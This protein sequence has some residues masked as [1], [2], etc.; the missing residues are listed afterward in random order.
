MAPVSP[1]VALGSFYEGVLQSALRQFFRRAS[2]EIEPGASGADRPLTIEHTVEP[3]AL[4][5][6]WGG[7]RY[8]LRMPGRGGA[9]TPHQIRMARAIVA[10]IGARYRAILNPELAAGGELFRGPIEDRYV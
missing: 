10:V 7:T 1:P 2:L 4:S 3:S 6:S 8:A 9:F 5:I